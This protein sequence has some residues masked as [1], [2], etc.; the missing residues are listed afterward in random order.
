MNRDGQTANRDLIPRWP[1]YCSIF[2]CL[3]TRAMKAAARGPVG[4]LQSEVI[5][6]PLGHL[7][8]FS[9]EKPS[10]FV[11]AKHVFDREDSITV[12]GIG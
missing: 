2:T 7:L 3:R 11:K 12:K 10:V 8:V 6:L 4:S 1:H 5:T 9:D